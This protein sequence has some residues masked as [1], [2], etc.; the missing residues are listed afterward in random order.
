LTPLRAF[1]LLPDLPILVSRSFGTS[2]NYLAASILL[3]V[4]ES[5]GVELVDIPYHA[6][7]ANA[8]AERWVRSVREECLDKVI[9]LNERHLRRVLH[10][11]IEYYNTR[12]PHQ[13]LEQD[14]PTGMLPASHLGTVRYR[15]VLGGIIRDYYREAA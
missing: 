11:Y 5:E 7:N 8:H 3:A 15:K 2:P 14:G 12:R 13:G 9:I 10:E 4:F 6:P 1:Q